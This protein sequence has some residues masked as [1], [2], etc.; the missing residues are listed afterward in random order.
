MSTRLIAYSTAGLVCLII[1][2]VLVQIVV[3]ESRQT[4]EAV[5]SVDVCAWELR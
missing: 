2:A 5:H 3:G 1:W 4:C